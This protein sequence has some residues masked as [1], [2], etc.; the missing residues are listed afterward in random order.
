[1]GEGTAIRPRIC[2]G[3]GVKHR[4]T[5]RG[6]AKTKREAVEYARGARFWMNL[7]TSLDECRA[8]GIPLAEAKRLLRERLA[9]KGRG[10]KKQT[11]QRR[12]RQAAH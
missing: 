2:D 9:A 6:A 4:A 12:R 5:T 8:R 7:R 3:D 10:T 11:A 1:M